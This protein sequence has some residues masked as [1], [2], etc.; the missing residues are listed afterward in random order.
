MP[1]PHR[2]RG[3]CSAVSRACSAAVS[4]GVCIQT[5]RMP[6]AIVAVVVAPSR[7]P[8][9]VE[10]VAADV[11]DPQ[12]RVA[13]PLQLG[14]QRGGLAGVAVAQRAA[15]DPGA[16]RVVSS[17]RPACQHRRL[18]RRSGVARVPRLAVRGRSARR[19]PAVVG[20]DLARRQ[21]R[22]RRRAVHRAAHAAHRLGQRVVQPG[23]LQGAARRGAAH[24]VA[25]ADDDRRPGGR[26][27]HG[28]DPGHEHGHQ[29]RD[30][31][32]VASSR[33]CS[34]NGSSTAASPSSGWR[35]SPASTGPPDLV[36]GDHASS[37]LT[38]CAAV[39]AP[40]GP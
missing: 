34:C 3:P 12:R 4:S 33:G 27:R 20:R 14:G 35:R 36:R 26:R 9:G 8:S 39:L 40:A 10:Q 31:R 23:G 21:P 24:P 28:V 5:L 29:P 6:V 15:P 13:E 16:T 11:G 22:R 38:S 37:T 25:G 30:R 7:L 18:P 1:M 2:K 19:Q 32:A 17:C